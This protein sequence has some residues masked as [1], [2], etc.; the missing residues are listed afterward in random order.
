[1]KYTIK[2]MTGKLSVLIDNKHWVSYNGYAFLD[3]FGHCIIIA[4]G[5]DKRDII[6]KYLNAPIV[7][8]IE[9]K[10]PKL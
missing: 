5:E 7:Q 4:Y 10:F 1:M 9:R 3:E 8:R 2:K 6:A